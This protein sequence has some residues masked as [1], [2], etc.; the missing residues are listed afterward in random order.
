MIAANVAGSTRRHVGRRVPGHA[1]QRSAASISSGCV[2]SSFQ[3]PIPS[4]PLPHG[5]HAPASR[6]QTPDSPDRSSAKNMHRCPRGKGQSQSRD[7]FGA[8]R[9]GSGGTHRA[10]RLRSPAVLASASWLDGWQGS[11]LCEVVV[12]GAR[13]VHP[14]SKPFRPPDAKIRLHWDS[15]S[16]VIIIIAIVDA[17]LPLAAVCVGPADRRGQGTKRSTKHKARSTEHRA[18]R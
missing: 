12:S 5:T 15:L 1:A 8:S 7:G 10:R 13:R 18:Q 16:I 6:L 11:H 9:R 4:F 3:L 17:V 2:A 14:G